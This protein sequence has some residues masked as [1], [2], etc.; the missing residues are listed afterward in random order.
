MDL[1]L[2]DGEKRCPSKSE[3]EMGGG[4][5]RHTVNMSERVTRPNQ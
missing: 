5:S 3:C 2:G 1:R 4:L